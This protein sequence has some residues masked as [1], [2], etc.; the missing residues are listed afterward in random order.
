MKLIFAIIQTEDEKSLIRALVEHEISVTSITSSGGFLKSGN[1]T[2]MIGAD[3]DHVPIV[4]DIIKHKSH[5]RK[6]MMPPVTASRTTEGI[7]TPVPVYVGGAT[8]FIVDV[9]QFI[10]F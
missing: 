8:L 1:A 5:R 2:L 6:S 9:A 10:K 3:E 4:L 7:P